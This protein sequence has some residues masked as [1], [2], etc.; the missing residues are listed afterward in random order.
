MV[1]ELSDEGKGAARKDFRCRLLS[2]PVFCSAILALCV[3]L[4]GER[5]D[6]KESEKVAE[7]K[8]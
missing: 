2:G 5:W 6:T 7:I 4:I 8:S 1:A 3:F